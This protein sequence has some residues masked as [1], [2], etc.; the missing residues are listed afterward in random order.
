ME[1][2]LPYLFVILALVLL[3]GYLIER[4]GVL[5]IIG[6]VLSS[7]AFIYLPPE[8]L[9][10]FF[11]NEKESREPP[12]DLRINEP[13]RKEKDIVYIVIPEIID[14]NTFIPKNHA[15][16]TPSPP[17]ASPEEPYFENIS[18]D[19]DINQKLIGHYIVI[20]VFV[21]QEENAA[22]RIKELKENGFPEAFYVYLPCFNSRI[23]DEKGLF[24]IVIGQPCK[25]LSA[26]QE[27]EASCKQR[28][29]KNN[30]ELIYN[31][32]ILRL[33]AKNSMLFN[34]SI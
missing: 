8:K 5:I 14:D 19:C 12:K 10:D 23:P 16:P 13:P 31:E 21:K 1:A 34:Q 7:L 26:T 33:E 9:N 6:L 18:I 20:D 4:H 3:V 28:A 11:G 17:M 32:K 29:L 30:I 25:L 24:A 2:Y 15:F 22:N 27:M